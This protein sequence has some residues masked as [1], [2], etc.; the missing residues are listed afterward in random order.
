MLHEDHRDITVDLFKKFLER[1]DDVIENDLLDALA[2]IDKGRE[3]IE[4]E[5]MKPAY[6]LIIDQYYVIDPPDIVRT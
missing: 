5:S 6:S 4:S 1:F 2:A 3:L